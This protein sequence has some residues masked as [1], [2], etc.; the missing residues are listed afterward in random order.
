[1]IRCAITDRGYLIDDA[2]RWVKNG[3]DLVQ[4]R[5]KTL[6]AGPL[7]TI[8]RSILEDVRA[9]R[10][11]TR[12]LVNG[13]AD[14]A[15]AVGA[16]GVHLTARSGELTP[17]QV[18]TV[19][20]HAG[21]A[22]PI[23]SVSCHTNEEVLRAKANGADYILFGPVFEKRVEGELI[24][25]GAGLEALRSACDLARPVAVLAIGGVNAENAGSCF[26]MGAQGFA[27]IR[28]FA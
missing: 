22:R 21:L 20:Q 19:F 10:G 15:A 8:A 7:A 4:L 6:E 1:M 16:A 26:R 14:V 28:T 5:D 18:R 3:V 11:K 17:E 13:R 12:L 24:D 25:D 27:S 2:A 23:V 9:V